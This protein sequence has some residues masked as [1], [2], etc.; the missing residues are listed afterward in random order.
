[1]E[2]SAP[3]RKRVAA[4]GNPYRFVEFEANDKVSPPADP[5]VQ[6]KRDNLRRL[7]NPYAWHG[8]FDDAEAQEGGTAS[9][10]KGNSGPFVKA[11]AESAT[12]EQVLQSLLDEVLSQ[13]RPYVA[14]N[15]W[16]KVLEFR[17][18]FLQRASVPG[19]IRRVSHQLQQLKFSLM[20][21]EK[22]EFNR[23]PAERIIVELKKLL[24]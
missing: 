9:E 10:S 11:V 18:E 3:F 13:Y 24:P 5:T 22:V 23:A 2:N 16:A 19:A 1:M 8:L 6:Q 20:P 21:G 17:A 7:E 4:Y 12:S 15:E 14:R